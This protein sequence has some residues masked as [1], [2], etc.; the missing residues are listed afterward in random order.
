MNPDSSPM[1]RKR[2]LSTVYLFYEGL[3]EL[4]YLQDLASG[5]STRI[6]RRERNAAPLKLLE[7]AVRSVSA[8]HQHIL[9]CRHLPSRPPLDIPMIDTSH[10]ALTRI[11]HSGC[12]CRLKHD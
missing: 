2:F 3:T 5:R 1:D 9:L 12:R 7:E 11:R 8:V 6:I 4:R 10:A